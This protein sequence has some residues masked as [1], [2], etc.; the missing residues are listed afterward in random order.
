MNDGLFSF[1]PTSSCSLHQHSFLRL[2]WLPAQHCVRMAGSLGLS[3]VLSSSRSVMTF[4]T[5]ASF[6][7]EEE[8]GFEIR[9]K[10]SFL[11]YSQQRRDSFRS[12]TEKSKASDKRIF[13][14]FW[15]GKH[16]TA[17]QWENMDQFCVV[18]A[19]I[20][21]I[22]CGMLPRE[23]VKDTLSKVQLVLESNFPG[24]PCRCV[25]FNPPQKEELSFSKNSNMFIFVSP[26]DS[27]AKVSE[28]I[29]VSLTDDVVKN[30]KSKLRQ[31]SPSGS[32]SI[33]SGK[34]PIRTTV[35]R[36]SSLDLSKSIIASRCAKIRG[37]LLMQLGAKADAMEAYGTTYFSSK[38]DPLWRSATME[39]I[40]ACQFGK[41]E[42][43]LS[44]MHCRRHVLKDMQYHQIL[45]DDSVIDT[46]VQMESS[47]QTTLDN[48]RKDLRCL[49]D[50]AISSSLY[51]I[52]HQ[53]VFA[54]KAVMKSFSAA[55]LSSRETLVSTPE[56]FSSV[57]PEIDSLL[58]TFVSTIQN[59]IVAL[60]KEA[61]VQLELASVTFSTSF[62]DREL[63]IHLKQMS[64]YSYCK[65]QDNFLSEMQTTLQ[66]TIV[67]RRDEILRRALPY[68]VLL[69]SS[70]GCYRIAIALLVQVAKQER[71][72]KSYHVGVEAMIYACALIGIDISVPLGLPLSISQ[73][74]CLLSKFVH[75]MRV[76]TSVSDSN[77]LECNSAPV[78]VSRG[79]NSKF[80]VLLL[81]EL[82][83]TLAEMGVRS[84]VVC[85]LSIYFLFRYHKLINSQNQEK[86]LRHVY[87][88]YV[89]V[90]LSHIEESIFPF[91]TSLK[92][93]PLPSHLAPRSIP[94]SGPM[95]TYIDL[96]RFQLTVLCLD[97]KK[98][99]NNVVW[100]VGD[101]GLVNI[102]LLNPLKH[103]MVMKSLT[104]RCKNVLLEV[105]G[106]FNKEFDTFCHL[107]D[108]EDP[109]CYA[110]EDV[111]LTPG[112]TKTVAL[113]VV[114]RC[115]G[116][117]EIVGIE[118]QWNDMGS[119]SIG[120]ST[121]RI[122]VPV[123][124]QLPLI[125]CVINTPSLRM[126]ERQHHSFTLS[127]SSCSRVPV[128]NISLSVH[129][130][131]CQLE[132]CKGCC[133][134]ASPDELFIHLDK[135]PLLAALPLSSSETRIVEGIVHSPACVDSSH[136]RHVHFRL[137]YSVSF[138]PVEPPKGISS[139]IPVFSIVP[140]RVMKIQWPLFLEVGIVV[141]RFELS[142]NKRFFSIRFTNLN[143]VLRICLLLRASLAQ[144]LSCDD[145]VMNPLAEYVTPWIKTEKV[146]D[147][148]GAALS[149][150]WTEAS[151]S[152]EKVMGSVEL[153]F[154]NL[155]FASK[156]ELVAECLITA[157]IRVRPEK[158]CFSWSS[159]WSHFGCRKMENSS[160]TSEKVD[161]SSLSICSEICCAPFSVVH[162]SFTLHSPW[163]KK[164]NFF[165][166]FSVSGS[167]EMGCLSG[168]TKSWLSL[169]PNSTT[170]RDFEFVPFSCGLFI[171]I[172][173][174]SDG[175][176]DTA[177]HHIYF[178][179]SGNLSV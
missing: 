68:C 47:M 176:D 5:S 138:P 7:E 34:I 105:E 158:R 156:K 81:N 1:Y 30:I 92:P 69:A 56:D 152:N 60:L 87:E 103:S 48:Y 122:Q 36:I 173:S 157:K 144:L 116:T 99:E 23:G 84:G 175:D 178:N 28:T 38:V 64:F 89:N 142:Y 171:L 170:V 19:V 37:D 128:E 107:E 102:A 79:A 112:E 31:L 137:D 76:G 72:Q 108:V 143:S 139:A 150:P 24:V 42:S 17:S 54:M 136:L 114:P 21:V 149:I 167:A 115:K 45:L 20:V 130:G 93:L 119:T 96:Q 159:E 179:V 78:E 111:P 15:I 174:L 8:S 73:G 9:L 18:T 40:A 129:N 2:L 29:L 95:F 51:K 11:D 106:E 131:A 166:S 85:Q 86:L 100:A 16:L 160:S 91:I 74:N 59:G 39:A 13:C 162:L 46:L 65:Q 58:D 127:I 63:N 125:S 155:D 145:V 66:L 22:H 4:C 82:I 52:L 124:Q 177:N 113:G 154:S 12:N 101:M 163:T 33:N 164:K 133:E 27:T 88:D 109:L 80:E 117:L 3:S 120:F 6:Y 71:K 132:D 75:R 67:R 53:D 165:C 57:Y 98:L 97:G 140:Q 44:D 10:N 147:L 126:F 151:T 94:I 141:K 61:L 26:E 77:S 168:P 90:P 123:I 25:V 134:V 41:V 118:C 153:D 70:C 62:A 169:A 35:D 121:R 55:V 148:G 161:G 172:L 14:N 146:K 110:L 104:L 135:L 50:S 83:D 49:K 43:F 32:G